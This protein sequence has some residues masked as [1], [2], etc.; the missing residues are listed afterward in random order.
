[1]KELVEIKSVSCAKYS[2]RNDTPFNLALAVRLSRFKPTSLSITDT[3][4]TNKKS[5]KGGIPA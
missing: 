3:T 1:M 4:S 2:L 5:R